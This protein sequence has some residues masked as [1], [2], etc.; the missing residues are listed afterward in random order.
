LKLRASF[1]TGDK[2]VVISDILEGSG[3][4]AIQIRQIP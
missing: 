4:E 2:V 1:E 3:I